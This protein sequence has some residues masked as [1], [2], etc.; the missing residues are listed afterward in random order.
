MSENNARLY[1]YKWFY[2]GEELFLG[3]MTAKFTLFTFFMHV[4]GSIVQRQFGAQ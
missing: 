4:S 2:H 3:N 1:I